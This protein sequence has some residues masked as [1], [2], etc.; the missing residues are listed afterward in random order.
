MKTKTKTVRCRACG[1]EGDASLCYNG[2]YEPSTCHICDMPSLVT[3]IEDA[4]AKQ[5]PVSE[6]V[7]CLHPALINTG[8]GFY[9]CQVCDK[10]FSKIKWEMEKSQLPKLNNMVESV[11]EEHHIETCK[12]CGCFVF[13]ADCKKCVRCGT[14][15]TQPVSEEPI[16]TR[17][18][19][20]FVKTLRCDMDC[21]FGR[22][23]ELFSKSFP[24][25]GFTSHSFDGR[26]LIGIASKVL[27]EDIDAE[28]EE[29]EG[30]HKPPIG[31]MPLWRWN[32]LRREELEAAIARYESVKKDIPKEWIDELKSFRK[33]EEPEE[34]AEQAAD[35]FLIISEINS[36]RIRS[37]F[38]AGIEWQKQQEGK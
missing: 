17:D 20:L 35:D 16:I 38:L 1:W 33:Y 30:I 2:E 29:P 22:I 31:L 11:S 18:Q 37:A 6:D 13:D 4:T 21:S 9:H 8:T 19:A 27:G 34:T 15:R 5:Q 26:D 24:E 7:P 23:A 32:E 14:D 3:I 12:K 36:E 25:T 10:S 28:E